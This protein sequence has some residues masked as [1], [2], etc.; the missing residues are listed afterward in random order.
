[1]KKNV[2]STDRI[3]RLIAGVVIAIVLATGTVAIGSTLGIIL[4]VAGAIFLFT[5]AVNWCAIYSLI[6]AST[7]KA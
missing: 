4:A 3:V 1:M 5:G 2:G 7:R 6:G